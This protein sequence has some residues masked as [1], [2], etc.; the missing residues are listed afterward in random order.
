M[1]RGENVNPQNISEGKEQKEVKPGQL[2]P[3]GSLFELQIG[4]SEE[5]ILQ[6]FFEAFDR[7]AHLLPPAPLIK[8]VYGCL[9][10]SFLPITILLKLQLRQPA[11][12]TGPGEKIEAQRSK[13]DVNGQG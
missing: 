1:I 9:N 13:K 4:S 12:R 3:P 7:T 2:L 10:Y 8:L 6:N 5:E 11:P